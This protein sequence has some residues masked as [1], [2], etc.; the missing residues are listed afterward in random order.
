[1][2]SLSQWEFLLWQCRPVNTVTQ[3][4]RKNIESN[5]CLRERRALL[6]AS[7]A[8]HNLCCSVVGVT[9]HRVRGYCMFVLHTQTGSCLSNTIWRSVSAKHSWDLKIW[10]LLSDHIKTSVV[11]FWHGQAIAFSNVLKTPSGDG[12]ERLPSPLQWQE[13]CIVLYDC[14]SS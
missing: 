2:V 3:A 11:L 13:V 5:W 8:P 10:S 9:L 7:Q 6:T 1:M 4:L 12:R 14:R